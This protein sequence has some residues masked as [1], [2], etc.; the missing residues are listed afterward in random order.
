MFLLA[1]L[2]LYCADRR[3]IHGLFHGDTNR[4]RTVDP[5]L[6]DSAQCRSTAFWL[7]PVHRMVFRRYAE[8]HQQLYSCGVYILQL[9][10]YLADRYN[11]RRRNNLWKI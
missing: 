4:S 10:K 2:A 8:V 6:W 5:D 7:W 1:L 3:V 9:F 11:L